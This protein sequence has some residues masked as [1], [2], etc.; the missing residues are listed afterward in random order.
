[1]NESILNLSSKPEVYFRQ[2]RPEMIPFVPT[3]AERILDI[4]CG[5]GGFGGALKEQRKA[6]VWGIELVPSAA[7]TARERLDRVL[8]GEILLCFNELP[9]HY[10]DCVTCN[11]VLEHLIDPYQVLLRIKHLLTP[12]GTV[13][14]SIPNIRYFRSLYNFAIRGEWRYE[15]AGIMDKTHLRFF[16]RKSILEMFAS[17]GFRIL[18]IEGLSP[19]PSWRVALFNRCT[20]G[21]FEDTRYLQFACVA[22][23]CVQKD[24]PPSLSA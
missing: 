16:T 24:A 17:L 23:P 2:T 3:T 11:D 8:T 14:C 4:G 6:E 21:A 12:G 5:E 7:E 10:F 19:T 15:D 18:R 9:E 22:Q 13:V 1:M 20:F